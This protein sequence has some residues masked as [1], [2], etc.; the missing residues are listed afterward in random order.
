MVTLG[1]LMIQEASSR[2]SAAK[3]EE[4]ASAVKTFANKAASA[5]VLWKKIQKVKVQ[6][7]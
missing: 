7:K 3:I 5:S 4:L 1:A 6:K 2:S